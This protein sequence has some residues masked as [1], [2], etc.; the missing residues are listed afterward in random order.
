MGGER[1]GRDPAEALRRCLWCRRPLPRPTGPGRPRRFC[2]QPCRQ[3]DYEARRRAEELGVGEH[4]L[5][6]ARA[7]LDALQDDLYVLACAVED[8]RRDLADDPT[9]D[10]V[11][12]ALAWLLDA[13]EPLGRTV[14]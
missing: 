10:D 13:A 3:R 7:T 4:E 11:R 14:R 9:P 6:V 8:V 12:S 5:V 1:G 2:S